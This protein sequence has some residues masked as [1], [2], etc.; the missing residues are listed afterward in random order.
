MHAAAGPERDDDDGPPRGRLPEIAFGL[1]GIAL[2]AGLVAA[3]PDLR[4][5][6]SLALH[7]NL[8][9]LHAQ[10]NGLG[11]AGVALLLGLILAHAVVFYPTEIVTATAGFVYGFLPG[12]A[13][14]TAGWLASAVLAYLLGR[15]LGRPFVHAVFGG[16]RFSALEH[17]VERGGVS[18]LLAVRLIP[19]V[20]FSLMGYI[21]GAVRVPLL[22]FSWTTVVGYL[23]LSALVAYLG[24]QARSLSLGD[25]RLWIGAGVLVALLGAARLVRIER[26]PLDGD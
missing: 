22:R 9:G 4:H 23:P 6:F 5:A 25:P 17:A 13:L 8:D 10:F 3:I 18:L 19:I 1:A 11:L 12:L 20:P 24:S 26:L 7:G 2:S 15:A 16:R 14:V 21:A